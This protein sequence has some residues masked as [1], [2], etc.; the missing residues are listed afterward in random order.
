MKDINKMGAFLAVVAA[1]AAGILAATYFVCAPIIEENRI[2]EINRA[3]AEIIPEADRFEK[4]ENFYSAYKGPTG[5]AV[6]VGR[7]YSVNPS[8][9]SGKIE[10]MV[11]VNKGAAVEGVKII[12]ILET[13][14]LGLNAD[15]PK[16]LNQ[17]KGK[18]LND[19][20]EP[21]KD[22]DAITGATITSKAI[23]KGVK[24]ALTAEQTY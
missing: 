6:E 22:I 19:P 15:S 10:M 14:G 23:A 17:F 5:E 2:M 3:L 21:K 18:S 4:R 8:G 7:V 13:P 11:G 16:F 20:I 1:L 9:Y 24:E 12:K